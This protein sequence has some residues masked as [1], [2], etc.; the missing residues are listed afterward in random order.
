[1]ILIASISPRLCCVFDFGFV[2]L[3]LPHP[4]PQFVL[5]LETMME[6]QQATFYTGESKSQ[7]TEL[8][9]LISLGDPDLR[10]ILYLQHHA[11][12]APVTNTKILHNPL[13]KQQ[14][15][16]YYTIQNKARENMFSPSLPTLIIQS[17]IDMGASY[18]RWKIRHPKTWF[19]FI[20]LTP[21]YECWI[22]SR[23]WMLNIIHLLK[24][25]KKKL[26]IPEQK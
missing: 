25:L 6:T 18:L 12:T 9:S 5:F 22:C 3:P 10:C 20:L 15:N 7:T 26:K 17:F 2:L 19:D 11:L 1:M 8:S 4:T 24:I 21:E 13:Q 14:S 16:R 23:I